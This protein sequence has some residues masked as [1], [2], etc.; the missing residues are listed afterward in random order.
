L[1]VHGRL[2][3][4]A[5]IPSPGSSSVS[6]GPLELRAYGLAI[7][8]GVIAAVAVA[9]RRW[10]A[11]GGDADDVSR[12]ATWSVVA[13]L[14]GARAYHVLTD[15]HRFRGLRRQLDEA[16]GVPVCWASAVRCG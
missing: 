10:A 7:A 5:A 16:G 11:R 12:L 1:T 15:Y 2:E 4:L 6:I 3:L 13:G 8:I 9:R 14:L